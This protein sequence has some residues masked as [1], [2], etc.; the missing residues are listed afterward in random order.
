MALHCN[1]E[2]HTLCATPVE[3]T[4]PQLQ[5]H[6]QWNNTRRRVAAA[7]ATERR[8]KRARMSVE[9]TL[10]EQ[11]QRGTQWCRVHCLFCKHGR[12]GRANCNCEWRQGACPW[13][14]CSLRR[15]VRAPSVLLSPPRPCL[16]LWWLASVCPRPATSHRARAACTC[17]FLFSAS[18]GSA[19]RSAS[20]TALLCA[21]VGGGASA[22]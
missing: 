14:L 21:R 8:R 12:E 6:N 3:G 4:L 18:H 22:S 5:V 9:P 7:V 19:G 16:I 10:P 2:Y 11:V 17:V 15:R 1:G 20:G 13:P